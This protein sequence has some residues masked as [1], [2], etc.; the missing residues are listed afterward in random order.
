[1]PVAS[2]PGLEETDIAVRAE[3]RA[4]VASIAVLR[5]RRSTYLSLPRNTAQI[6]SLPTG[7]YVTGPHLR[8]LRKPSAGEPVLA[9][10][11]A[12]GA[13]RALFGVDASELAD[14]AIA[15][16]ELWR[17]GDARDPGA[18]QAELLRRARDARPDRAMGH[19]ARRLDD[20]P[21]LRIDQLAR[22]LA[23]SERQLLRRFTC[24]IGMSPKRYAR[25]GRIQRTLRLAQARPRA[26]WAAIAVAAGFYDQAHMISELRAI[27]GLTPQA[28]LAELAADESTTGKL[29]AT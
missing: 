28:L 18:L 7:L 8:V 17:A 1:M 3:L 19:A 29:T 10:R 6:L 23:L 2:T 24:A 27:A 11:I 9:V 13:A 22:E 20:D 5:A 12:P 25:A 4:H 16:S 15:L 14:R 21:A 26:S